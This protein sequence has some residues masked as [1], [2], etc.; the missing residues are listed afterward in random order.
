[1][2][3]LILICIAVFS[4]SSCATIF[5]SGNPLIYI[6]GDV[7]EPV[8]I[9]TEKMTYNDV[10]LPAVVEVNRH[11]LQG[12]RIKV[13]SDNYNYTDVV[14]EKTVNGVT[15]ANFFLGG[16]IGLTIDALTNNIVMPAQTYFNVVATPKQASSKA[17]ENE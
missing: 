8:T 1:M 10:M 7:S 14:L 12:Q 5:S 15:F 6:E 17:K 4:L 11:K 9:T 3:N 2:K 16:I 13:S